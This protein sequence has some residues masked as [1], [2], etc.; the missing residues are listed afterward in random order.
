MN[1]FS[2]IVIFIMCLLLLCTCGDS[3]S[4]TYNVS[5][6]SNGGEEEVFVQE[7]QHNVPQRL[8]D[9][10]FTNNDLIFQ[11]WSNNPNDKTFKHKAKSQMVVKEDTTLYA[12][13]TDSNVSY[14]LSYD[15]SYY[16]AR[17]LNQDIEG[18]IEILSEYNGKPVLEL[19]QS[20]FVQCS[21]VTS[22]I[23]PDS[24]TTIDSFAFLGCSSLEHIA[25]PGNLAFEI[26]TQLPVGTWV[27]P[28]GETY[29][30]Q[31]TT[32]VDGLELKKI[33]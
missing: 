14:T 21:K 31:L 28:N 19:A 5:F 7:F 20:A 25:L 33:K 27:G 4:K 18:D 30:G 13:W 8:E 17:A 24:V 22:I 9:I 26:A 10:T 16:I 11:G 32:P 29:A 23:V 15:N 1:K 3:M 12:I 2:T 6:D